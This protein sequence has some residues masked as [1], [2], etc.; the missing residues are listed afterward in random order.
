[1]EKLTMEKLLIFHNLNDE[2]TRPALERWFRRYHIH[3]VQMQKPWTVRYL[4]YRPVPAPEGAKDKGLYTYR[5]HENW[6]LDVSNRRGP[7]G[8]IAM[9]PEPVENAV[10]AEVMEI[11]AEPTEDF[12]GVGWSVD[13]HTYVRWI[14]AYRYPAGA[15]K[16]ECEK[17]FLE[18]Q[19][20]EIMQ[21][22]GLLRFFSFKAVEKEGS[23]LPL[24]TE[25]NKEGDKLDNLMRH[26]DR[27]SELWFENNAAWTNALITNPPKFTKPAWATSDK[28]PF[29]EP[30]VD[31][32]HTFILDYPD[33]D[34]TDTIKPIVY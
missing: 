1:M 24:T 12:F 20:K 5:V 18:T 2:D 25:D 13:Q 21:M 19:A 8:M 26:W 33:A 28:F 9:T 22:P 7:L 17:F 27:V 15:D 10:T 30:G 23:S 4:L 29:L 6:A 32:V 31:F 34:F 3:E 11:P 16:E 14:I